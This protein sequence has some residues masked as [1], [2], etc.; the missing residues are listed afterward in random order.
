MKHTVDN[1]D[2]VKL[3]EEIQ[4]ISTPS[5]YICHYFPD[6]SLLLDFVIFVCLFVF[7]LFS[8][9]NWKKSHARQSIL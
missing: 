9:L 4:W 6:I 7:I 3:S 5:I 8:Y 2:A 1:E